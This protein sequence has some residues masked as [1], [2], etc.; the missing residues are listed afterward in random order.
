MNVVHDAARYPT[1]TAGNTLAGNLIKAVVAI[2][3]LLTIGVG[4]WSF[5]APAS[6][7]VLVQFPPHTHFL[8]DI[9]AFQIGIGVTLLLALLWD[10]GIA[11]AL[12][13]FLTGNTLHVVSHGMDRH[14]GGRPTDW[15]LLSVVSVVTLA[16]LV[17]RLR[18]LRSVSDDGSQRAP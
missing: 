18:Q 4:I 7:A 5:V 2:I 14:L 10:D 16:A 11:V 12:G 9:G 15:L 17:A 6:F 8:H 3:G 1:R 13:G